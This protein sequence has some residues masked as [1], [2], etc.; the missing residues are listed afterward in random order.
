MEF[1]LLQKQ[2][3][4]CALR[5][6]YLDEVVIGCMVVPFLIIL[7]VDLLPLY[8]QMCYAEFVAIDRR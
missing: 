6:G 5:I 1:A 2:V 4:Y 7:V 8:N 3:M